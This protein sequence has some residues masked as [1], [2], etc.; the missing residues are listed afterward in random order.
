MEQNK[1]KLCEIPGF[2]GL[3]RIYDNGDMLSIRKGRLLKQT[4]NSPLYGYM[5][6]C[7][8]GHNKQILRT[9]AHRIVAYHFISKE[10]YNNPL[11]EINHKDLDKS[12]NHVSNLEYVTH[13]S[14]ILH[15]RSIKTWKSGREMGYRISDKT[16]QKMSLKKRKKVMLYND[17]E[18][19]IY[20]SIT[21][22]CN[23]ISM[24]HKQFNRLYASNRTI[25]GLSIKYLQ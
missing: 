23:S 19:F 16:K 2:E 25:N 21:D 10:L 1:S 7:L 13:Q 18:Q 17:T 9:G 8:I 15:A 5:Y 4:L 24:H 11:Y 14:N 3:Y 6:V 12:N 22:L 20:D